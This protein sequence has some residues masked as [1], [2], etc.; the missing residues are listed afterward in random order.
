M[1]LYAP[2]GFATKMLLLTQYSTSCGCKLRTGN[3]ELPVKTQFRTSALP[4]AKLAP[5][6]PFVR[7]RPSNTVEL[8]VADPNVTADPVPPAF[9]VVT[10]A[11]L[12]DITRMALVSVRRS[13]YVPGAIRTVS[14]VT[15]PLIPLWIVVESSGTLMTLANVLESSRVLNTARNAIRTN[16]AN[17][18]TS[19][20]RQVRV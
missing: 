13:V 15:A 17:M 20:R 5:F 14:P 9:T 6:T 11:P 2:L 19:S 8:M 12:L 16:E 18:A 10:A 4:L 7:V 3:C 1:A